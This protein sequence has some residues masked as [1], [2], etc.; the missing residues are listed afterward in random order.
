MRA[1]C[2]EIKYSKTLKP[3]L[4]D[5]T[6]G[7]SMV[8]PAGFITTPFIPAIWVSWLILPREPESKIMNTGLDFFMVAGTILAI[9]SLVRCQMATD[10]YFLSSKVSMP[11]K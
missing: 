11:F 10:L 9:S 1:P 5:G 7:N 8:S 4:N 2:V 6:M 3:S